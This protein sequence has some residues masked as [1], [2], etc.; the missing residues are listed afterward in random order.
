VDHVRREGR[1]PEGGLA[2]T[3]DDGY[4]NNSEVA[5]PI[6]KRVGVTATFFVTAG[7]VEGRVRPWWYELRE[8]LAR[9]EGMSERE[10][11]AAAIS[12]EAAMRPLSEAQRGEALRSMGVQPVAAM[13]YPFMGSE[14]CRMLIRDGFD[15]Q[16][17]GD[18]HASLS[19]EHA[20][21]VG[22]EI[23][24][25][26]EFIRG[27]GHTPWAVAYPYGH[28]PRDLDAARRV[29]EECGIVAGV[30]T[31]EEMNRP[32]ED[33]GL[34]GRFDLHGGYSPQGTLGKVSWG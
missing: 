8:H 24:R 12:R 30:T 33:L 1:W 2:I 28:V 13:K 32:G 21:R 10:K 20:E 27:L 5:A 16:C 19:G 14:Q 29:M 11:I 7:F 31:R 34:L 15:V 18:T 26:A 9:S 23:R 22:E 6:L 3:F 17:H 25:S 4:L